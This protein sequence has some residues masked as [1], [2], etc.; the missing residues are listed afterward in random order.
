M[1]ANSDLKKLFPLIDVVSF[2]IFDT[3]LLR[4]FVRP[5]DLFWK[6]EREEGA[7]GFAQARIHGEREARTIANTKG[8]AEVTLDEI[9]AFIPQWSGMKDKELAAE[10][11]CLTVD[12][13]MMEA[14]NTAKGAG[15]KVVI[16]SD[17]YLP[18]SF[19]KEVLREKGIDGWDGFYLSCERKATKAKGDLYEQILDDFGVRADKVLHIGDNNYSDVERAREKGLRTYGWE[20]RISAF[21][22]ENPF[23]H[24][25]IKTNHDVFA[26]ELVGRLAN[27]WKM[28][29]QHS[30]S[31]IWE[32]LGFL[33]GGLFG[34][35]YL[36]FVAK[37]AREER[38]DTLLFVARDGWLME[39]IFR[40]MVPDIETHYVYAPR[41]VAASDDSNIW[42]EYRE[43]VKSLPLVGKR[44]GVVDSNTIHFSSQSILSK[45][46]NRDV[47]GIFAVAFRPVSRGFCFCFSP[48]MSLRWPNFLE[49]LFMAPTPPVV[50]VKNGDP[51]YLN[52]VPLEEQHRIDVYP[53][54]AKGARRSAHILWRA[55][56]VPTLE[57]WLDWFDAF[58][59]A[60]HGKEWKAL[61]TLR[62][63]TD[64]N[65]SRL[66]PVITDGPPDQKWR[67]KWRLPVVLARR[68]RRGLKL[69]TAEYLFGILKFRER[70][71]DF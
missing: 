37:K 19:L 24:S 4:P 41:Q 71:G 67:R 5:T 28:S 26:S 8:I 11:K 51:V 68:F 43:Y 39:Q 25:F 48:N 65:H 40:D 70:E 44:I 12:P 33:F 64:E 23:V 42:K 47:F 14:W 52:P 17:M 50:A 53:D 18:S 32:R 16:T 63:G 34:V 46:L 3:L 59:A 6:M 56:I 29:G 22:R 58:A 38:L 66:V 69:V 10:Q 1:K 2:D 13:E 62:H 54:V 27:E 61:R 35:A 45:A 9:Y 21:L 49:F 15:K 7:K 60:P 55:G 57:T 20:S 31:T 30:S 36:S